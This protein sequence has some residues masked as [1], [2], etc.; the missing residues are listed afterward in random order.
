MMNGVSGADNRYFYLINAKKS[1][2]CIASEIY[3]VDQYRVVN[4]NIVS[5][6]LNS[7]E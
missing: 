1:L 4:L 6:P 3:I 7:A 2:R 5:G